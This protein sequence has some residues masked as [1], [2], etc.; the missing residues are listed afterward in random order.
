MTEPTRLSFGIK[1]T[2][3]NVSFADILRVWAEADTIP[4]IEH[5]WLWDHLQPMRGDTS[6]PVLEGWTALAALAARTHRLRLGLVV[7]NNLIRP[8]ALLAKIAATTDVIAEGRLVLGIGAGGSAG[9]ESEAYGIAAP[10]AG[11]RIA[12]LAESITIIKRMFTEDTVDFD[13]RYYQL[14]AARCEPKPVH[15]P[16]PPI[17][18]GGAGER[19][20]LRVVAENADIW[21]MPGPPYFTATEFRRKCAVLDEHCA[22]IGRDPKEII[23]SVQTHVRYEDPAAGRDT[24][25]ELIEAGARHLVLNLPM[26]YPAAPVTWLAEEIIKPVAEKIDTL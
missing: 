23:R 25:L 2:P 13:G 9:P 18:I 5:A 11:E 21:N 16:H 20:T 4:V 14:T 12:R 6:I 26:P 17:M 8:P 15:R 10:G 1:T 7:T 3:Q 19:A 24:L 22:A